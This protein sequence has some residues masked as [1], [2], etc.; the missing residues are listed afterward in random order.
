MVVVITIC[1]TDVQSHAS[2]LRKALQTVGDHLG[3]QIADLLALEAQVDNC[4]R[5]A[6]QVNDSPGEGFVERGVT[7]AE[8][9][10]GLTSTQCLREGF[11]E[12]EECVFC[13]VVV[14]D[15]LS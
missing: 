6:G 3:A 7:A 14:V 1:A 12:R 10:E 13:G 5:A 2:G 15:W 11:A 4:P 9:L 8:S